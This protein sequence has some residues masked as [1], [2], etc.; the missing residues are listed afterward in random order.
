MKCYVELQHLRYPDTFD[1]S[2]EVDEALRDNTLPKLLLQPVVE[3]S[4]F[5]GV[6]AQNPHPPA[7]LAG[8]GHPDPP[9]GGRWSGHF[10]RQDRPG[11]EQ[12]LAD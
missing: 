7:G 3:N 1:Y 2:C 12:G 5:H 6:A 9:G 11:D 4:L 10:Q 8:G